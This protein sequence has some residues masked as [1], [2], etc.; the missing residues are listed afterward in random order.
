LVADVYADKRRLAQQSAGQDGAAGARAAAFPRA[1]YDPCRSRMQALL[2]GLRAA[3]SNR[4]GERQV[5]MGLRAPGCFQDPAVCGH[6]S[7]VLAREAWRGWCKRAAGDPLSS[8]ALQAEGERERLLGKAQLRGGILVRPG[9][10]PQP[11]LLQ[12]L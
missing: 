7:A 5:G 12:L 6:R 4:S 9:Q 11:R 1:S 8:C 2:I 10:H 3:L